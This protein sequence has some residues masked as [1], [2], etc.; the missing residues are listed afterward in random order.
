MSAIM[1]AKYIIYLNL[2]FS[3]ISMCLIFLYERSFSFAMVYLV[4]LSIKYKQEELVN[5]FFSFLYVF[6]PFSFDLIFSLNFS[7]IVNFLVFSLGLFLLFFTY[8]RYGVVTKNLDV[9]PRGGG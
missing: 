2:I 6:F 4:L 3:F 5:M 7:P 8:N 1:R 9:E